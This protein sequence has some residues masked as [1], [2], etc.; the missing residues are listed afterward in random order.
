MQNVDCVPVEFN[1]FGVSGQVA[2]DEQPVLEK[3]Q[4]HDAAQNLNTELKSGCDIIVELS[5]RSETTEFAI[6]NVPID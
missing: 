3:L 2:E 6:E 4:L 5:N 1:F